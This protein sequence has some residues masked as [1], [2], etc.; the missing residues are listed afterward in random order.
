MSHAAALLGG[1]WTAR[2]RTA[3]K[4]RRLTSDR[5]RRRL[6]NGLTRLVADAQK[7]APAISAAIPIRR[8]AVMAVSPELLELATRLRAPGPAYAQGVSL[9]SELLTDGNSPL[10][11]TGRDLRGAVEKALAALDGHIE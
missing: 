3:W 10:Y 11:Q 2:V 6:A 5:T 8:A 4:L 7:P 1:P 9:A